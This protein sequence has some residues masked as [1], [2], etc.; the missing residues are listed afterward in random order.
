MCS[1]EHGPRKRVDHITLCVG[2]RIALGL[3]GKP[4]IQVG[5]SGEFMRNQ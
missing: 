4:E 1:D 2:T 3:E 5:E